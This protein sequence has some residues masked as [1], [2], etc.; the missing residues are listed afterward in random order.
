MGLP[1]TRPAARA[2]GPWS[3]VAALVVLS[4][5]ADRDRS[6][7]FRAMLKARMTYPTHKE[8]GTGRELRDADG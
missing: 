3:H 5:D 8:R 4:F 1:S 6:A 2:I 7:A